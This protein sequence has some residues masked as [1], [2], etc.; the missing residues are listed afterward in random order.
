MAVLPQI[1][2]G[3]RDL[4]YG[5]PMDLTAAQSERVNAVLHFA[6]TRLSVDARK[7]EAESRFDR[8]LWDEAAAFGLTGLPI[9][10]KWGG[11]GLDAVDTMLVVEAL[12]KGSRRRPGVFVVRAHVRVG[13][14]DL[15]F[16]A[17]P[18]IT[19]ATCAT[20]PPAS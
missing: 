10:E 3:Y 17:R 2:S 16:A 5:S 9:P 8:T 11:S 15:A 1:D 12:G 20:S 4:H 7:R 18:S 19:S 14:A 13:R 6:R